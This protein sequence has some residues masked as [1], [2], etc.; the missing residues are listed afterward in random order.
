MHLAGG[1]VSAF[2]TDLDNYNTDQGL[3]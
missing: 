1:T 3:C 2:C